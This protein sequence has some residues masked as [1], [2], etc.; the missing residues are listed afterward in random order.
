MKVINDLLGYK[1]IKI[2]QNTKY[3]S[4]SLD[5]VLLANFVRLN[6][7]KSYKILDIGTGNAPIPLILST[8][9]KSQIYGF[10]IQKEIYDLACESIKMNNLSDRITVINDDINNIQEYFIPEFF[11]SIITN[12]PY[13]KILDSSK[14]NNESIKAIAR[15]EIH[16]NL[17]QIIEISFK[18]LKNN[19]CFNMV[20]RTE[21][22]TEVLSLMSKNKIEPKRI[23]FVFS[24]KNSKSELFL[25]EGIKNARPGLKSIEYI[26]SH[27]DDGSYSD[28][29]LK[30]FS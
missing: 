30:F 14:I 19:G 11:D 29:V 28:D 4:F 17:N 7:N 2:V 20:Y 12:P 10:E 22:L 8:K 26:V 1:N 27:N 18:Y 6:K 9:T 3:F 16:L 24:K 5:S 13:F 23:V 21:R 15:H 25:V